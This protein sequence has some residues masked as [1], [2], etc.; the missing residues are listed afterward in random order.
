MA[1]AA[2]QK[3]IEIARGL[4]LVRYAAAEDEGR[5]PIVKVV[6]DPASEQNITFVLHPDHREAVLW[7][8]D[9]C[10]VVR[11]ITPGKLSIEV[12]P[13]EENGPVAATV[14]IEPLNQGQAT[15]VPA[16]SSSSGDRSVDWGDFRVLGHVAS[17]GD[18]VVNAGEW[19]AGPSAPSRIE[20]ISMAWP[21]KSDDLDIYYSVKTARP[22]A[23]SERAM[24]LGSFAG[25]RGKALPIVGLTLE[26]SGP[27]VANL[28]FAVDALF[29]GSPVMRATG[30][31]IVLNGPTGREP[32]VGLRVGL[33][34]DGA[35]ARPQPPRPTTEPVR[36]SGRVRVF[37]SRPRQDQQVKA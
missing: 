12:S 6:P 34:H 25:T 35:N 11:A 17:V 8:P 21:S 20:G 32:L 3:T 10:L 1:R 24:A 36:P 33:Q 22:Q 26:I 16:Q 31:L 9:T 29:L 13:V 7:Q 19:L 14:R 28:Q 2:Q 23:G 5:P 15:S 4:F 27:D 18:V 30:K 37:R